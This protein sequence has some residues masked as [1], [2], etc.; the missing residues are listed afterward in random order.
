MALKYCSACF[1]MNASLKCGV[2]KCTYFCSVDC[3]KK[4][5]SLHKIHCAISDPSISTWSHEELL[6]VL[7][8]DLT[9]LRPGS[10]NTAAILKRLYVFLHDFEEDVEEGLE[11]FLPS[12]IGL[13]LHTFTRSEA[14]TSQQYGGTYFSH[15]WAC[16]GMTQFLLGQKLED[17]PDRHP[18]ITTALKKA[19]AQVSSGSTE[20]D[21]VKSDSNKNDDGGDDDD[22]DGDNNDEN[23]DDENSRN[24]SEYDSDGNK[25][26]KTEVSEFCWILFYLLIRTCVAQSLTNMEGTTRTISFRSDCAAAT[27]AARRVL[28]MWLGN[29]NVG[30]DM[31][32]GGS[33]CYFLMKN[34]FNTFKDY[35]PID[36]LLIQCMFDIIK[37]PAKGYA[38]A[39]FLGLDIYKNLLFESTLTQK[40]HIIV[41]ID[42]LLRKLNYN[43]EDDAGFI[44]DAN[45][46]RKFA[47]KLKRK[48]T[49]M[50]EA[51]E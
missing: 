40:R 4:V 7:G 50:I 32:G 15:L 24:S 6:H 45:R 19:D 10:K 39:I 27:P 41:V 18:D 31:L 34:H 33:V 51:S 25:K 46:V 44:V 3:Q 36:K 21:A 47:K 22:K 35:I 38:T 30:V 14:C 11:F 1:Q 42:W 23:S 49:R 26:V 16:P 8:K 9:N 37:G 43:I 48:I 12:D 13:D 20:E 5:H 2:C 17:V 29:E 28:Q